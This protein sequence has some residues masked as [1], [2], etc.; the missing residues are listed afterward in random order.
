[1]GGHMSKGTVN[2]VILIG[3]LGGDPELRHLPS[4]VAV[5][6]FNLATNRTTKDRDGNNQDTTDWHRITAWRNTAEFAN[7]YLRKGMRVYVEGRIQYRNW[8]DQN[9][10][11]HYGTDIIAENL[12]ILESAANRAEDFSNQ[13][14]PTEI[15]QPPENPETEDDLPF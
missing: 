4:G 10:V 1:M 7:N 11:K 12:Q 8:E 2:K 5:A 6:T 15:P 13:S 14:T 9:G 3:R